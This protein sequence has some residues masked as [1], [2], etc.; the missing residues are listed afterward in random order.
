MPA[1]STGLPL[2]DAHTSRQESFLLW[3]SRRLRPSAVGRG[4]AGVHPT[5]RLPLP[6]VCLRGDHQQPEPDLDGGQ[7]GHCL[8]HG[9][10]AG[11]V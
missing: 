1:P 10:L 7:G 11:P 2:R 4:Q 3:G 8:P 6:P 9:T 5:P